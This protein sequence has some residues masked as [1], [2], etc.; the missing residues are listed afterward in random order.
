M[1]STMYIGEGSLDFNG[2][3]S[4][5]KNLADEITSHGYN[6]TFGVNVP[7]SGVISVIGSSSPAF[8]F[9]EYELTENR[10]EERSVENDVGL[11]FSKEE[12]FEVQIKAARKDA[13][14]SAPDFS[15]NSLSHTSVW[16]GISSASLIYPD[17]LTS[18]LGYEISRKLEGE[19]G[20]DLSAGTALRREGRPVRE[21]SLYGQYLLNE[22]E[23]SGTVE[24]EKWGT[25]VGVVPFDTGSLSAGYKGYHKKSEGQIWEHRGNSSFVHTPVEEFSYNLAGSYVYYEKEEATKKTYAASGALNYGLL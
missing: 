5:K 21:A 22:S 1:A 2:A 11:L 12:E 7:I 8:L 23:S 24:K 17:T 20:H 18:T 3:A 13:W 19:L 15:D 16:K 14:R 9:T 6:G 10:S 25:E 4:I